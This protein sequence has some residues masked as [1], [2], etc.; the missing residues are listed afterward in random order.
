MSTAKTFT[1]RQRHRGTRRSVRIVDRL[2]RGLI[3]VGGIGT[4]VAVSTV[5]IFLV[6]VV[7]PLFL[8]ATVGTARRVDVAP[9]VTTCLHTE[10]DDYRSLAWAIDSDGHLQTYRLDT[11]EVI[12]ERALFPDA[13]PT[14]WNF[15]VAGREAVCGFA[16]GSV[17]TIKLGF[18]TTFPTQAD[19]PPEL[20]DL[21]VG[22]SATHEGG[23]LA[24]TKQGQLRL[25]TVR[26]SVSDAI[27]PVGGAAVT[28]VDCTSRPTGRVCCLLSDD[29][30]LTVHAVR[31]RQSL[32]RESSESSVVSAA[33]PYTPDADRG[34]PRYLM[35]AGQADNLYLIWNDGHLLRFDLRD[36]AKPRL[37]EELDLLTELNETITAVQ[38]LSGK[39]TLAVGDTL[40]RVRAWF[41]T[42]PSDARTPD[43]T[44]LVAAHE[45][46]GDGAAASSLA[47]SAR[48]RLL[49][50][51]YAD[52]GLRVF[53]VTSE[54]PLIETSAGD[55]QPLRLVALSPKG[56]GIIGVSPQ[57]LLEWPLAAGFPEVSAAALFRSVWYEGYDEPKNVW[58][59]SGGADDFEPKLGM[60]PLVFGTIKATVYSLLFAVPLALLSAI[61]TSEFLHAR[62]KARI[63]PAIEMMASL[64]SVVLGFVAAL[65]VAPF[66]E[67]VIP[68]V[69]AG[70]FMIPLTYLFAAHLWQLLPAR[71]GLLLARWRFAFICATLPVGVL[72]SARVGPLV[73][74]A[75]FDGDLRS[76]L[77][78][79]S[80]TGTG[81]WIIMF[82]P[83]S[84]LATALLLTR[85]VNPAL[86]NALRGAGRGQR[87]V[88]E[89]LKFLAAVSVTLAGAAA[90][91]LLLDSLDL[92][93][94]GFLL[95]TY[96]QRNALVVGC[97]MVFAII[98]IIY[99]I[100][101]DA[102]ST[103]PGHLRSASLGAGATPWQ[104]AVRVIVPTAM[105][106]LFSAVMIGL[107]RAVG[108]TM[109]V[110]MA[111]GNTPIMDWNIFNGFQT[112]SASI[113]TELPEAV[114]GSA[115]Y[116]TLFV[117]ALAL[118][119]ITF[120]VNTVAE[121]VRLRFRRRAYE[122]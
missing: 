37:A 97:V 66:V 112:L 62:A 50:V 99:T 11:G 19:L 114:Q 26:A 64:P 117:A 121:T 7:V 34:P 5:C 22:K 107:G 122:L 103:V 56:D 12:A 67:G 40:G 81:G 39:T 93:P 4:V 79:Q 86:R 74:R 118:F 120:L 111:A 71:W 47:S 104:T 33:V 82:L 92:D 51:G 3:A 44:T 89:L 9:S 59:S 58:Q 24:R 42:K 48:A 102:L 70:V 13:A 68:A 23:L 46:P 8:P 76:W 57:A 116:R 38:F 14:A 10:A 90:V 100:A 95:N 25:Q 28:R 84:A 6:W 105:S 45:L 35:L 78:G 110:L 61:Y 36:L 16:D 87:A 60:L 65:V 106:G 77:D 88:I 27:V 113:A 85:R 80:G 91:A 109:I 31:R 98:P 63:K 41:P 83:L 72:L 53:H 1:G 15:G 30:Q 17:R 43:G 75:L 94:R 18:S 54:R 55:T 52:G 96:V 29:G 115:H 73:E 49:A 2:A 21:A 119:A 101:D 32:Q 69:L 108:E 20:H